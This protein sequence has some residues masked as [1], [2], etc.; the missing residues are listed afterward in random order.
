MNRKQKVI[1]V[2]GPDVDTRLAL[3]RFLSSTRDVITLGSDHALKRRFDDEGF[4]FLAYPLSRK[5]NPLADLRS[6]AR[7]IRIFRS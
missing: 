7:L 3:V 5:V 1:L 2:G 6:L 4:I